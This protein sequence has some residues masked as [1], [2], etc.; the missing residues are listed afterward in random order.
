MQIAVRANLILKPNP[1]HN[2][3]EKIRE[4]L[5]KE[6]T[7]RKVHKALSLEF[8]V[9]PNK[10]RRETAIIQDEVRKGKN[11]STILSKNFKLILG[12][13]E[14]FRYED[15]TVFFLYVYTMMEI[16]EILDDIETHSHKR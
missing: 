8:A 15:A 7:L 3:L 11:L 2:G 5:T 13:D 10:L 12:L 6:E 4:P 9:N 14:Y 16:P 1:A